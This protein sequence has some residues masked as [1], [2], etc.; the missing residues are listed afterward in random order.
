MVEMAPGSDCAG[1]NQSPP[2][3]DGIGNFPIGSPSA[4]VLCP[5]RVQETTRVN[6]RPDNG[7]P[8]LLAVNFYGGDR[9]AE[10]SFDAVSWSLWSRCLSPENSNASPPHHNE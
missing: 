3:T 8:E 4:A 1:R 7:R 5:Y 6:E 9:R 10:V 2:I